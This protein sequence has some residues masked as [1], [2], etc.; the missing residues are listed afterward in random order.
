MFCHLTV[1]LYVITVCR[2]CK[3][4]TVKGESQSST[5]EEKEGGSSL[6]RHP[7]N[8]SRPLLGPVPLVFGGRRVL[9]EILRGT[10]SRTRDIE[11]KETPHVSI[12]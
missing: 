4:L 7:I 3:S 1:G 2:S 10:W 9:R 11:C 5:P 6:R 12:V 8:S